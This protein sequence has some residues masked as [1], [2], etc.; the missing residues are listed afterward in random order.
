[1]RQVWSTRGVK[2]AMVVQRRGTRS[3]EVW[4]FFD[5][6][7]SWLSCHPSHSH[8]GSCIWQIIGWRRL[9]WVFAWEDGAGGSWGE[10]GSPASVYNSNN[11]NSDDTAQVLA[12]QQLDNKTGVSGRLRW[13]WPPLNCIADSIK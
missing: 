13:T 3:G 5:C 2:V 12:R 8:C 10:A 11:N 6:S 9:A 4:D 1:M 7:S